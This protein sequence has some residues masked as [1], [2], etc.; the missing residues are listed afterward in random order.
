MRKGSKPPGVDHRLEYTDS[1]PCQFSSCILPRGKN[2]DLGKGEAIMEIW[3]I[4]SRR[5]H[6]EGFVMLVEERV[7]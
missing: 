2:V 1:L 7:R 5:V 3:E 4:L 6:A